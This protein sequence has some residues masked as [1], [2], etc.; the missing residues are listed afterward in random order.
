M[1]APT[2]AAADGSGA[3]SVDQAAGL[4]DAS[5]GEVEKKDVHQEAAP[6]AEPE[7]QTDEIEPGEVTTDTPEDGD[8][9]AEEQPGDDA[10]PE[11]ETAEVVEAPTW[12]NAEAKAKF[13][14]LPPDLR[15]VVLEQE[16]KRETV[17]Q[18]AKQDAADARKRAEAE[19]NQIAPLKTA[20]DQLLPRATETFQSRWAN[21]DWAAWADQ[22]PQAAFKA[23][24]QFDAEASE[25]DRLQRAKKIADDQEYTRFLTTEAEKLKELAPELADDNTGAQRRGK[26]AKFLFEKGYSADE[27]KTLDARSLII[28][29]KALK[30]EEAK[31]GM[32]SALKKP[33]AQKLPQRPVVKPTAAVAPRSPNSRLDELSRKRTLTN[34]EAAEL[35]DLKGF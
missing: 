20:L 22:D 28:A 16:G 15:A 27:L 4:L 10:E 26:I 8:S 14:K 32:A 30:Y 24:A 17:T 31:A 3:L 12:W 13:A 9:E 19:A 21:I 2:D 25:L 1:P 6:E 33:P 5:F 29:D 23:K 11:V 7:A 34:D 18:K 35:M